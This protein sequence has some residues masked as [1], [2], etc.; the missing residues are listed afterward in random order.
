MISDP[1]PYADPVIELAEIA[2]ALAH[3]GRIRILEILASHNSCF[4]GQIVDQ[5][6][7][8]QSTV[9]QHLR[10]LKRVGLIQ[11]KIAGPHTCYCLDHE[12]LN[13]AHDRFLA[14]FKGLDCCRPPENQGETYAL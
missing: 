14:M 9:S 4:C 2:R 8:S 3:P 12:M 1:T 13:R 11:G 5:L 7:L 10:E 6:P